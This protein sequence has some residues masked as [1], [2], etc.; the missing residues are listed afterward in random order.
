MIV[1]VCPDERM[2]REVTGIRREPT[3]HR[4]TWRAG[5]RVILTRR[6]AS[7]R[8]LRATNRPTRCD[9]Q[10]HPEVPRRW[11]WPVFSFK[12]PVHGEAQPHE[13]GVGTLRAVERN[14]YEEWICY[15]SSLRWNDEPRQG[16]P[17]GYA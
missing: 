1:L 3:R 7:Q 5:R 10:L 13:S 6:G 8:I 16:W 12:I 15:L 4:A 14:R 11:I 9:S 17:E 2:V